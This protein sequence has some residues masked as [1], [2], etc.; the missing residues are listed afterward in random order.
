MAARMR[1]GAFVA[2]VLVV[3]GLAGCVKQAAPPPPPPP[4]NPAPSAPANEPEA[5]MAALRGLVEQAGVGDDIREREIEA[6]DAYEPCDLLIADPDQVKGGGLEIDQVW[7]AG[8]E[9]NPVSSFTDI[10]RPTTLLDVTVIGLPDA[11]AA[12]AAARAARTAPC[13]RE[14]FR[15]NIG[16]AT[17]RWDARTVTIESTSAR[18][19]TAT[20]SRVDPE[21]AGGMTFLPGDAR[22]IFAHGRLLISIEALTFRP[23]KLNTAAEVTAMAQGTVTSLA[24]AIVKTLPTASE[25]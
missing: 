13:P 7:G 9:V 15:L 3:A 5:L 4:V 25:G 23:R 2:G 10:Q 20:V 24:T 14:A 11:A 22:L 21:T 6:G 12:V 19:T 17:A 18:L 8:L 16:M 1:G